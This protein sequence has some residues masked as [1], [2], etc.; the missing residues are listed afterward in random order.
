MNIYKISQDRNNYSYTYESA[1][2]CAENEEEARRI[3]PDVNGTFSN[4]DWFL[5]CWCKNIKYIKV[6]LIGKANDNI[7]KGVILASLN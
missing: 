6:E 7:K 1:I 4:R 2:V 5:D 3:H